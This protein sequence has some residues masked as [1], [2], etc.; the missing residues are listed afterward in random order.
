MDDSSG[1]G[2]LIDFMKLVYKTKIFGHSSCIAEKFGINLL[3]PV[4]NEDP[5]GNVTIDDNE[6]VQGSVKKCHICEESAE[7]QQHIQN[8]RIMCCDICLEIVSSNKFDYHR[9]S[10]DPPKYHCQQCE[11]TAKYRQH[12]VNHVAGKHSGQCLQ[13]K[14]ISYLL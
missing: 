10:H 4:I 14:C 9:K 5:E 12:L 1:L 3:Y 7:Q 13:F 6:N 2:M 11:Y 8:H